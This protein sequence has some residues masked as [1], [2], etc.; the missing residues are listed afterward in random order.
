MARRL[1]AAQDDRLVPGPGA[2]ASDRGD[3]ADRALPD[4]A[5]SGS[6]SPAASLGCAITGNDPIHPLTDAQIQ[7][8]L[9]AEFSL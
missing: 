5:P 9:K 8:T 1:A 3:C 6:G 2:H 4:P 7:P